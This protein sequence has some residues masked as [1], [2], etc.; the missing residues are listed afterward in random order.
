MTYR[1]AT[2][3]EAAGVGDLH[4]GRFHLPERRM[5]P[6]SAHVVWLARSPEPEKLRLFRRDRPRSNMVGSDHILCRIAIP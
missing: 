1:K 5:A 3:S 4:H 2:L 6:P